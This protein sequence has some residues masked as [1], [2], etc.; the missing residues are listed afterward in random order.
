VC[1]ALGQH[2]STQRKLP[3]GRDDED[4]LTADIIELARQYGRH[5]YRKV[6]QLLRST[7]GWVVNDKRVE[8]IWRREG[9][10]VPEKQP[11]RGRLWLADGSCLRL[12]AECPNHVWSYDFVE[13]RTHDGRKY[14]MLN[15]IDEFT[16]EC[17]A[18]RVARKLKATDVIDVLSDLFILRGVPGHIRSD[19]GPEF[20]AKAVQAW[21]TAVGAKTAYIAPGSPWENG[22]IESFNARLRDELLDGEIFYSLRE[23][24]VV[25]ESW[26][27]HYNTVRPHAS[28]GYR[29]PAPE[30]VVP[31]L[32]MRTA[33][34][35]GPTSPAIPAVARQPVMH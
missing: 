7:A 32:A 24:E 11:K 30:V 14:R 9:L 6:A 21:I 2:R 34:L 28:L 10:K 17:L 33:A 35:R 27:R 5:G 13:D 15:V 3:R 18:I 20:V 19:N 1:R 25:I 4:Q 26:R 23:A 8:R 22:F 29:A 16:H 31:D 12:R